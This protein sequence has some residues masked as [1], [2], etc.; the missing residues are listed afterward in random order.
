MRLVT[1]AAAQ[2]RI[3]SRPLFWSAPC[4]FQLATAEESDPRAH[5]VQS[6]NP[7]LLIL[8]LDAPRAI[9]AMLSVQDIGRG[10]QRREC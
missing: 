3:P 1:I 9:T 8:E 6:R 4:R 7:C 5:A 2:C 10:E